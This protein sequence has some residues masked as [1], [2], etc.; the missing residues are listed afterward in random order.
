MSGSF[1]RRVATDLVFN[2]LRVA[3]S[4][5]GAFAGIAAFFAAVDLWHLAWIERWHFPLIGGVTLS[6]TFV[7]WIG[8]ATIGAVVFTRLWTIVHARL[9]RRSLAA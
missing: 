9:T 5:L 7:P 3:W 1:A 6:A 8:S 4:A 2:V